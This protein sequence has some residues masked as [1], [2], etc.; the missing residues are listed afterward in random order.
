MSIGADL[1]AQIAALSADGEAVATAL[2]LM[3]ILLGMSDATGPFADPGKSSVALADFDS[4]LSSVT[5]GRFFDRN[6]QPL[7]DA[8]SNLADIQV[9]NTLTSY[10]ADVDYFSNFTT[11]GVSPHVFRF[12][13]SVN[14][15]LIIRFA[16][17]DPPGA[18]VSPVQFEIGTFSTLRSPFYDDFTA[19][20]VRNQPYRGRDQSGPYPRD[21][22]NSWKRLFVSA[23]TGSQVPE[24]YTWRQAAFGGAERVTWIGDPDEDERLLYGYTERLRRSDTPVPSKPAPDTPV[25]LAIGLS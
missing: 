15:V 14:E 22:G 16:T 8:R 19:S 1:Q 5:G 9:M 11:E 6:L 18:I 17:T 24:T 13:A 3:D 20:L 7:L 10:S 23:F 12:G 2:A 4:G 25:I 21:A